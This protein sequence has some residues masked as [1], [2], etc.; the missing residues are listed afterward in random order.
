MSVAEVMAHPFSATCSRIKRRVDGGRREHPAHCG[1]RWQ[2][3]PA[4]A[5]Q[6]P[7]N[8]LAFQLHPYE[9]E[10]HGHQAVVDPEQQRLTERKRADLDDQR[11]I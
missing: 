10:E 4:Q 3:R 8:H 9:K 6:V 2:T 1:E 5:R 7:L 11:E